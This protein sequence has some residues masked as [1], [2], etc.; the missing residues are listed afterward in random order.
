[1]LCR[2]ESPAAVDAHNNQSFRARYLDDGRVEWIGPNA[3]TLEIVEPGLKETLLLADSNS[4]G[5]ALK[6]EVDPYFIS[7]NHVVNHVFSDT[8]T[9]YEI[10]SNLVDGHAFISF[11]SLAKADG[12]Q[13]FTTDSNDG[14][15]A[16]MGD[17]ISIESVSKLKAV[18]PLPVQFQLIRDG[19]VI[20]EVENVYE[21]DFDP[22]NLVGNYRIVAKL[23]LDDTWISW[24]FTNSIYIH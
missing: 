12:F 4:N 24:V 7:F 17:S 15:N 8:L 2:V 22:N 14:I 18:S 20:D 6:W 16:I 19:K 11:Q 3:K 10:K 5:W 9:K 23:F 21:Y 13:Y 1:M